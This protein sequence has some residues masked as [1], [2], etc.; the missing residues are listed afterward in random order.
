MHLGA[1]I[2]NVVVFFAIY[3][4]TGD[5]AI[6]ISNIAALVFAYI[7]GN[8]YMR[9]FN[10]LKIVGVLKYYISIVLWTIIAGGVC[11]DHHCSFVQCKPIHRG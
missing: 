5:Y 8:Y 10:N 6:L 11:F 7:L 2:V 4:Y 1:V 3:K 9:K